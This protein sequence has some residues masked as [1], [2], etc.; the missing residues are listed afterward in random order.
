MARTKQD[1]NL[2]KQAVDS[3]FSP[4]WIEDAAAMYQV[5]C[6]AVGIDSVKLKVIEL[7][8]SASDLQ[9]EDVKVFSS[10]TNY[11]HIWSFDN[12]MIAIS[13]GKTKKRPPDNEEIFDATAKKA[14]VINFQFMGY[15]EMEGLSFNNYINRFLVLPIPAH[16]WKD[17]AN[18]KV[19]K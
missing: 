11:D 10:P 3:C 7:I 12:H 4:E 16:Q 19:I 13:P 9:M 8:G 17:I 6:N 2:L 18:V 5:C 15:F 14:K 1:I